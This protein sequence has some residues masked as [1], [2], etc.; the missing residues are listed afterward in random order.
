MVVKDWLAA[1]GV[2][3]LEY[4][5]YLPDLTPADCFLFPKLKMELADHTLFKETFKREWEGV[6]RALCKDDYAAAFRKLIE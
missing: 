6:Y 1:K 2:G 5:Q 4:T 3:L